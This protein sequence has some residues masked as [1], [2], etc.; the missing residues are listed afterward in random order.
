MFLI[1]IFTVALVRKRIENCDMKFV[2]ATFVPPYLSNKT[3]YTLSL[4]FCRYY[5]PLCGLYPPPL[6]SHNKMWL[7]KKINVPGLVGLHI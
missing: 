1:V 4:N 7:I 3:V 2:T 6:K 5:T